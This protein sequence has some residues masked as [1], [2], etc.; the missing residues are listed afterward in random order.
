[1]HCC[2]SSLGWCW[3]QAR[4]YYF[5]E[6]CVMPWRFWF[7]V[8]CD[9][10]GVIV[11]LFLF[12]LRFQHQ[13]PHI[14]VLMHCSASFP[15]FHWSLEWWIKASTMTNTFCPELE[16]LAIA[17]SAHNVDVLCECLQAMLAFICVGTPSWIF[18]GEEC[19][20]MMEWSKQHVA[21]AGVI[22]GFFFFQLNLVLYDMYL[23]T[24]SSISQ[25]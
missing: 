13:I 24:H 1:M 3:N 19:F 18:L 12:I 11:I 17:I 16:I 8:H 6:S 5:C 21:C 14:Q 23:N 2:H 20:C 22:R 10:I 15:K 25:S 4:R 7:V 9:V